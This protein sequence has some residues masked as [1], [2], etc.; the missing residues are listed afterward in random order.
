MALASIPLG[1]V[2]VDQ[3]ARWFHSPVL[4]CAHVGSPE[5]GGTLVG[6]TR[7]LT[8][9]YWPGWPKNWKPNCLTSLVSGTSTGSWKSRLTSAVTPGVSETNGDSMN[10]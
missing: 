7:R 5:G 3:L 10:V 9:L 4:F 1:I 6:R 8:S 2:T